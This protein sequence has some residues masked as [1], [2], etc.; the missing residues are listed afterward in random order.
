MGRTAKVRLWKIWR[1]K[2]ESIRRNPKK[3]ISN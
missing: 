2:K 3:E 1:R